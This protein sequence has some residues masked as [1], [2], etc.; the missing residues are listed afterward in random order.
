M[1]P[2]RQRARSG[3][4]HRERHEPVDRRPDERSFSDLL[5][6]L[7]TET[8]TLIRQ[9]INLAKTELSEKTS[10]V[11]KDAGLMGAGGAIAYA[12]LIVLAFGL[13][14]LLGLVMANWLAFV[15]VGA[16][17]ALTGYALLQTGLSRLKRT[18]LSLSK[19]AETLQ[20]DK[21]WMKEEARKVRH[22]ET[23][24]KPSERRSTI[25]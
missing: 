6:E 24:T 18:D 2:S 4:T 17:V 9:E 22:G 19:T 3:E 5:S 25:R 14:L 15:I 1:Q 21:Q 10:E 23:E 8:R 13:A 11:G 16:A 20:E 12:G 7:S